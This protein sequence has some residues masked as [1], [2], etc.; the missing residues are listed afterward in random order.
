ML[1]QTSVSPRRMSGFSI[2]LSLLGGLILVALI[3]GAVLT[4][5]AVTE[6]NAAY[7]MTGRLVGL[8]DA[9]LHVVTRGDALAPPERTAILIHGATSTLDVLLAPLA[10]QFP[11]DWRVIA[12]DRPGHGWSPRGAAAGPVSDPSEQARRIIAAMQSLG[13]SSAHVFGHSLGGMVALTLALDHPGKVRSLTL[14]SPV[15]HPWTT[16]IAWHYRLTTTPVLGRLFSETIALPAARLVL[17]GGLA[18]AF[19]PQPV[20]DGY[21]ASRRIELALRPANFRAN[22]E[23]VAALLGHVE[24]RHRRW[25]ELAMP[26]RIIGGDKDTTVSTDIHAR[27][28]VRQVKGATLQ[29]QADGGHNLQERDARLIVETIMGK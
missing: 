11:P 1:S 21:V 26:V 16:G 2:A 17:P 10:P 25:S 22:A 14:L 6:L 20:P 9:P 3:V 12:M 7:P 27:A 15:S 5:R 19:Q 4:R 18:A 24:A 23:D 13:V 28:L 29:V 8:P